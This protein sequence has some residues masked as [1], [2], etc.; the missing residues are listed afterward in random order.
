MAY[1]SGGTIEAVDYN[2]FVASVNAL[3]GTGSGDSGYGQSSTLG[4]VT[5]NS[6]TVTATQW[7]DL[8]ARINSLRNHQ[9]AGGLGSGITQPSAGNTI[10]YLSTMASQI[11]TATTNR[12]L[13]AGD[14]NGVNI[15][16]GTITLSNATGF[17][18]TRTQEFSLT[19]S[20]YNQ[21]R[22]FFNTGG[23]VTIT[24]LN[25][26]LSGN[27]K[28]TDWDALTLAFGTT[29]IYAQTS[30]KVGGSGTLNTNNTNAGFYD[31]LATDTLVMRQYSTTVTGGYNTN[32]ISSYARLNVAH[33]SSPTVIYLKIVMQDDAADAALP[34]GVDTVSGTARSDVSALP[35]GITYIANV[36][37]A[38]TGANTVNT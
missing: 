35:S 31:L 11:S 33:A 3:W 9:T 32:Y 19:F 5:A 16:G 28:S 22:Y 10:T 2:G 34:V 26:V 15:A 29:Y 21:M 24:S 20:S 6:S 38:V 37:G 36:W 23:A 30:A 25:S 1:A 27:T 14:G 7:S 8:I 17:T 4:T 18:V 12:L 13:N